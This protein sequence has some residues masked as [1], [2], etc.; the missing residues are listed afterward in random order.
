MRAAAKRGRRLDR[1][2]RVA[3][4]GAD[5]C[6]TLGRPTRPGV[7]RAPCRT[8]DNS[9]P[10]GRVARFVDP[11]VRPAAVTRMAREPRQSPEPETVTTTAASTSHHL[12]PAFPG[13]APW[14]T[15]SK[16][17]AWQQGAM[18]R[19]LQEQPRDFLAVATPGAGKTTFALTLASWLLHH[20]VVQ[21]VTVVAPT[22]HLKKQWAEAAARIGIKLDPE[23]SAGPAEQGVPRR[24]RHVRGRRRAAH[25]APQPRASSARPSSSSTRS[26]TPVTRK[27]W[28][29]AC[30]E[31]FEPGDPP[32]RAHRYA[33]PV[34]HQPHP[35][36]RVRG[37]QRRHPAV[38][39]R[40]H[41][42]LRQRA[43]PT[44]S[45]G[46]SSSSPTAAT[47]AGAPRPATRS[48]PGSASR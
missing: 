20:H 26:T 18:E 29:E 8:V 43:R 35:L 22:E 21:Q 13:R 32:A 36:R 41:L 1:A 38:R 27:S 34:R 14:G 39:R 46:P 37:G 23:Y 25:A 47:C 7:T 4:D 40:L 19:Y 3:A 31:A 24:R 48:P 45:C 42:R 10:A 33:L 15:A 16:L 44:A 2:E 5:G 30:L 9:R 12:S 6:A 11:T 28:G 17:R